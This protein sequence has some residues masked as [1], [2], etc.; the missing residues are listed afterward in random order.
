VPVRGARGRVGRMTSQDPGSAA[1][2]AQFFA[3]DK[4]GR[5]VAAL[6]TYKRIGEALEREVAGCKRV[7]DVGNGG[8]FQY[9]TRVVEE[10]VAVDLFLDQLPPSCF[11]PN[12]VP[13]KGDALALEEAN[14]SFDAVLEALL[15]HHLV[16]AN[17]EEL[18][19][20]VR[21]AI[22]EAERVLEPGGRLIVAESC[23]PTWFYRVEK[24]LFRPLLAL[25]T[26]PLLGGHPAVLQ[27]HF[28]LLVDLIGERF[29]VERAYRIPPGRW[30]TQFGRRWPIILTPA[31][32]FMVVGRKAKSG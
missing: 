16:G 32:A 2:N 22:A 9:D 30:I 25:A 10:I 7:L 23:V 15:Y 27:L 12:V 3:G 17:P 1:Q 26:T 21:R 11:P 13:R 4:H 5:D 24:V 6:D 20:N 18:V 29:E 8:V 28:G 14:G 31:R 19:R